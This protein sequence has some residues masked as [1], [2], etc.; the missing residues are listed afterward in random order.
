MAAWYDEQRE[1]QA[2]SYDRSQAFLFILRFALLFALAT[3]FWMSGLSRALAAGL[4]EWFAFPF[5]WPLVCASFTA[6]A[7]FGYEAVL[8][9]LSVLADYSLER[10]HGRLEAEFG[11]WLKGFVLTLL[12]EMGI[13]TAGFTGLYVLM[14]FFPAGWWWAA[15]GAYAVMV[16]GLGEW[17][18]SLLLPRVRPPVSGTDAQLE[19]Q[20][21][22]AGR[23]AGLEIE[24]AAWWNFEHQEDLDA[25]RLAGWGRRRRVVFS[26][27]AWRELGRREQVFL[28]ARQMAWLRH[29]LALRVQALQVALAGGVFFG[30]ARLVDWVARAKGLSSA[31]APEA[32]PFWVVALFALAA[33]AGV[34]AHAVVRRAELLADRFALRQAGGADALRACLRHEFERAPFAMDAPGW[35]VALLH[36]KPTPAR[37]LAQAQAAERTA[38]TPPK[39]PEG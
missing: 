21:R 16:A 37:R 13:V 5:A 25:V 3:V 14:Y 24:G 35:Q 29:G 31:A 23:A 34:I 9:P 8:F 12:I 1:A 38:A 20:L 32:F 6:L 15:T 22:Q 33:L 19:E 11:E 26:A 4:K 17:G 28:A 36:N 2:R 18:P 39:T 27:R 10:A 7:V 30:A